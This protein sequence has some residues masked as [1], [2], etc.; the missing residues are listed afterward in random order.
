MPRSFS[1][2]NEVQQVKA[3]LF[4]SKGIHSENPKAEED[5]K[6]FEITLE[7]SAEEVTDLMKIVRDKLKDWNE[8]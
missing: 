3:T 6:Q 4:F 2:P 7:G 1:D 8:S 5:H